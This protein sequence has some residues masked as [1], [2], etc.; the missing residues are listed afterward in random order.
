MVT[1]RAAV[2]LGKGQIKIRDVP[3]PIRKPGEALVRIALTTICGTDVQILRAEF[4]VRPGLVVGYEPAGRIEA[5]ALGVTGDFLSASSLRTP[6][7]LPIS[8]R[9]TISSHTSATVS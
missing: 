8:R 7:R 6:S 5:S 4:P 2:L 3:R 1:M 9:R